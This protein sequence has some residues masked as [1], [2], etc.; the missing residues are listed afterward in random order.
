[1]VF[2]VAESVRVVLGIAAD[3]G[4]KGEGE[5][6]EDQDDFASGQ[7]EF[8]FSKDFDGKR[9]EDTGLSG[10]RKDKQR[11]VPRMQSLQEA[12]DDEKAG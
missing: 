4:D 11:V 9:V 12:C 3:H 8:S 2:P 6:D 7:P 1:M 10:Q 5:D